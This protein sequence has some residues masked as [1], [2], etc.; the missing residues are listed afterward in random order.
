MDTSIIKSRL[1]ILHGIF[2]IALSLYFIYEN[3]HFY[4]FTPEALGKYINVSWV[5]IVHIFCGSLALLSGPPLLWEYFRNRFLKI[6]RILGKVYIISILVSAISALYL[7]FTT[8]KSVNL[9]Y[10]FSLQI[11]ISVWI[12]STLFAFWSV[13]NRKMVQHKEWMVRSY[14]VTLAFIGQAFLF[15]LPFIQALGTFEEIFSSAVW[16]SWSVPMTAFQFYLSSK[17]KK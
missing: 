5:I 9:P 12:S 6:H 16:F 13:K 7:T 1:K 10:V 8:A 17:L 15:K 2:V 14:I 11:L 3:R 4:S